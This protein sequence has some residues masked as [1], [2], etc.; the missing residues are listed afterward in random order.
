[1]SE[2]VISYSIPWM[3]LNIIVDPPN[4]LLVRRPRRTANDPG[5]NMIQEI[6][7]DDIMRWPDGSWCFRYELPQMT[8]MSDDYEIIPF[9]AADWY[10][11]CD[12]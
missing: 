1:M 2:E 11:Q 9:G 7:Q 12:V 3:A 10:A 8:H 5:V 6:S 4:F